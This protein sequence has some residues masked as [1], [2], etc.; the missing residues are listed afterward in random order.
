MDNKTRL[1]YTLSIRDPAPNKRYTKTKS[2]GM[3]KDIHAN[4]NE[5]K[6]G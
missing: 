6:L 5:K 1:I 4:G 2:R 3:G